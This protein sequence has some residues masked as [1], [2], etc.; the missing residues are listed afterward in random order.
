MAGCLVDLTPLLQHLGTLVV[1]ALIRGHV[2][3]LPMA[4]F[5]VVPA[6]SIR[7]TPP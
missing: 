6:V 5:I 7:P 3:D 4:V 1:V 2:A